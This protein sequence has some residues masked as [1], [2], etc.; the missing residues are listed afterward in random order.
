MYIIKVIKAY[1][2][3]ISSRGVEPRIPGTLYDIG[4]KWFKKRMKYYTYAIDKP[5]IY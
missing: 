4:A 5:S 2:I 3:A 1:Y